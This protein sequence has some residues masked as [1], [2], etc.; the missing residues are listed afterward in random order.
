MEKAGHLRPSAGI[1]PAVLFGLMITAVPAVARATSAEEPAFVGA[2]RAGWGF[3]GD[4]DISD[5]VA[6]AVI[7]GL[8][9]LRRPLRA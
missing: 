9:A 4:P 6:M 8:A 2:Q 5:F 7:L 3:D 1:A